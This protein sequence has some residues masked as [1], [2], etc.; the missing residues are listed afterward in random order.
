MSACLY[1]LLGRSS[2]A[3]QFGPRQQISADIYPRYHWPQ[4]PQLV[5]RATAEDPQFR[6]LRPAATSTA[7]F[8]PHAQQG[9]D[10]L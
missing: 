5:V 6:R 2:R 7:V 1:L 10:Q 8:S 4:P 9:H 3:P